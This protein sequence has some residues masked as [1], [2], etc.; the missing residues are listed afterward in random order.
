MPVNAIRIGFLAPVTALLLLSFLVPKPPYA[1]T[2]HGAEKSNASFDLPW[3]FAKLT[4]P[5]LPAVNDTAWSRDE[6]D[7]F[8]L[9]RLEKARIKPSVEAERRVLMRRVAL[10][11]TGLTPTVEAVEAFVSDKSG[12]DAAFAK[13]VDRFLASPQFGERWGRHWLDVVRYADS[14]GRAWNAPYTYAFRYRDYVIDAFNK[15]KPYDRFLT[16]QI[17]GDLLAPKNAAEEREFRTAPG[18]LAVG[19]PD[20][21]SLSH[22][23]FVMDRVDDQIDVT[24]RALLGLS[25]S[26]ARC[27]DHKY[28]PV[29][30]RD[31]YAL[32][33]IF[34]SMTTFPGVAHQRESGRNGYVDPDKLLLLPVA[35]GRGQTARV[36]TGVHS[37]NDY[38]DEWRTGKRD[39]RFA[40]DPNLAMG[41]TEGTPR[42]CEIRVKGDPHDRDEAPPRGDVKI[43]GLPGI[44]AISAK[45]SGRLELARWITSPDN[46]LTARVM[47]NRVWAHLFGAGLVA[48]VD[49][50]GAN[51][52]PP[53]NPELLDHLAARFRDD[54]WSVKKLIRAI[55]LSRTYRQSSDGRA[56]AQ[57][58]DPQNLFFWRMNIRRLELEPLRDTLLAVSGRLT[59]ERPQGVQVAGIGGKSRLSAVSSLLAFDAPYRTVYIPVI[60]SRVPEE[61]A[62]FDF[63]DPCLIQG[64]REVT[65]VAPQ[66]LFFMNSAFVTGCA[67][68]CASQLL[69]EVDAI[70]A[71]RV[72]W[73]Y[74]H[75]L[76]RPADGDEVAQAIEFVRTLRPASSEKEPDLYR[77]TV[78]VQALLSSAEFRYVR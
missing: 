5:T 27:H 75:V 8:V 60:R 65:T 76:G 42:D 67:R 39:I 41:V 63:P 78:L 59:T 38:Q 62:T 58:I 68:R 73:A 57:E 48:T 15:D 56:D 47:A 33:G 12:D 25:I 51:S 30:M 45:N 26:C 43:P 66:A 36:A 18:F 11:L 69:K 44:A 71:A 22:E 34:Y 52:E 61:Y 31:Y 2:V 64:Q 9:A 46:P 35:T 7:R 13:V 19:S 3:S 77:W 24:T 1:T 32:A 49:D 16:E 50:F 20:L 40:T 4:R 6:L 29:T 72:A 74:Q 53:P 28:D 17:A 14:T 10:D 55:V 70:D 23:Q 37:M 21:Q 54:G